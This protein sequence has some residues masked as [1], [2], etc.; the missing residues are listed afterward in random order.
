VRPDA[1]DSSQVPHLLRAQLHA[2]RLRVPER[3]KR[4]W[5]NAARFLWYVGFFLREITSIMQIFRA[6]LE[7]QSKW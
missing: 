5:V 2:S 7:K 4:P 3:E 1:L 6:V